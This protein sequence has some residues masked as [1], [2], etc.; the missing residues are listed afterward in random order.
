LLAVRWRLPAEFTIGQG[1]KRA[2]L[3][4]AAADF[5]NLW[6]DDTDNIE[7]VIGELLNPDAQVDV[8][9]LQQAQTWKAQALSDREFVEALLGGELEATKRMRLRNAI[10]AIGTE[11]M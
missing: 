2:D 5:R 3:I 11:A 4:S 6:G 9:L 10:I 8:G 1:V 7:G